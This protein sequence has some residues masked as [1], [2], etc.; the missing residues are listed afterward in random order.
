MS[1]LWRLLTLAMT[2]AA[3]LVPAY[4][5][6]TLD[7]HFHLSKSSYIA[8]E[9]VFLIFE[10]KNTGRKPVRIRT[11]D[12]LSPCFGFEIEIEGV[13]RRKPAGC[14]PPTSFMCVSN[15]EVLDPSKT[16]TDRILL[17]HSYDIR[18]SGRLALHVM[19]SISYA[20]GPF[21]A[22]Q[23]VNENAHEKFEERLQIAIEPAEGKDLKVEFQQYAEE[24]TSTDWQKEFEAAR[25]IVDLAPPY[26]EGTILQMLDVRQL[27]TYGIEGL[28]NLATPTAHRAL[29]NFVRT[30]SPGPN[31]NEAIQ[32]LGEI[33]DSRD[34]P[35][36]MDVAHASGP[37]M[38]SRE[39]ALVSA[40]EAGGAEAVPALMG[41]LKDES[42]MN[43]LS[44]VRALYMTDSRAA[45]PMLIELLRTPDTKLNKTAE[46]GLAVLTHRRAAESEE[47]MPP[48]VR[49]LKW[50]HWWKTQGESATIYRYDQCG[51]MLPL[52]KPCV[53]G[54]SGACVASR[55]D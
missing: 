44:A 29:A 2:V 31:E 45:V 38:Y 50:E 28:R 25:V 20:V 7:G 8:G 26:M 54:A 1:T 4:A 47:S 23:F 46:F 19:H 16:H 30:A 42:S 21:K 48:E 11:A 12:P 39:L 14:Y 9:P 53:R 24:L 6:S 55:A 36:L 43:R 3:A 17:N 35:L 10:V 34:V 32:Y 33:G 52:E 15:S 41:A 18:R 51:E 22:G 40:G 13:K 27:Q 37:G 49:Y 5:E